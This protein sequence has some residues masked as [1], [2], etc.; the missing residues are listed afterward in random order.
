M[1]H[2][3][4]CLAGRA[5]V[6]SE[7]STRSDADATALDLAK[8]QRAS[9][10]ANAGDPNGTASAGVIAPHRIMLFDISAGAVDHNNAAVLSLIA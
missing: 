7:T 9:R 1:P 3:A 8:D 6:K 4:G 5:Q 10:T 2:H